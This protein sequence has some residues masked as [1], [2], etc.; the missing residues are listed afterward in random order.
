MQGEARDGRTLARE[1][2]FLEMHGGGQIP[3]ASLE[4]WTQNPTQ[5]FGVV[6]V[7]Y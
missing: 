2:Y 5:G 4:P 7:D 3:A 6:G 1:A